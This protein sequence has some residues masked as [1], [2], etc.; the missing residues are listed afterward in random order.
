[1]K[2]NFVGMVAVLAV[3]AALRLNGI[4]AR[5]LWLDEAMSAS[6][7]DFSWLEILGRTAEPQGVH[8]PLYFLVM[9]AWATVI[10][11]SE[12]SLRGLSA[13]LGLATI[14]GVYALVREL[15]RLAGREPRASGLAAWLSATL[16]ALSPMQIHLSR[17]ARGYTLATMLLTL[18]GWAL[19]VALRKPERSGPYWIA[20]AMLAAGAC[21]THNLAIISVAAQGGFVLLRLA[22][23]PVGAAE[24]GRA[25]RFW[26]LA[27]AAV[28]ALAYIVPWL[29]RLLAQTRTIQVDRF[30]PWPITL[31]GALSE[32]FR[33]AFVT[34]DVSR[35]VEPVVA[36]AWAGCLS[37]VWVMLAARRGPDGTFLLVT[38]AVPPLL[39]ATFSLLSDRSI[40]HARYLCMAQVSWLAGVALVVSW[41]PTP[42]RWIAAVYVIGLSAYACSESWREIG[43]GAKPGVRAAAREILAGHSPG[44]P[45]LVRTPVIFFG[46]KYHTRG[47]VTPK[48]GVAEPSRQGLF[49]SEHLR[50]E[51]LVTVDELVASRPPGCW[52]VSTSSYDE[53]LITPF[54]PPEDWALA[55]SW[56]FPQD[57]DNER[58]VSVRHYRTR[59]IGVA[60]MGTGSPQNPQPERG[61]DR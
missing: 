9:R 37:L 10:G 60:D 46:I 55:G 17:I 2:L 21:Y 38:G 29:P 5:S 13:A 41:L 56:S 19:V 8:P 31:D 23:P 6:F 16:V 25:A 36:W 32:V 48:L 50:R 51:D 22:R 34:F 4:A 7:L 30:V 44:E 18:G 14:G 20:S 27:G 15:G 61:R 49:G 52:V 24:R 59:T 11:D 35:T 28:F 53:Q 43:P 26:A 40:L 57:T 33:A 39:F 58:P 45:I 3:G 1:M 42:A 54:T 47:G 12:A